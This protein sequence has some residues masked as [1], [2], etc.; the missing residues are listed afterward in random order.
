MSLFFAHPNAELRNAPQS[1]ITVNV[2][3]A[4]LFYVI[5]KCTKTTGI[6]TKTKN[7]R[8]ITES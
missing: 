3:C 8:K 4:N 7:F 2:L 6:N 1:K 5:Q